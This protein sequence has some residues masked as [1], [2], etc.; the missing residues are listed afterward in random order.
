M[1][2]KNSE[3]YLRRRCHVCG[4]LGDVPK[5]LEDFRRDDVVFWTSS[6]YQQEINDVLW[7]AWWCDRCVAEDADDI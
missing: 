2:R 4:F 5:T 7:S 1:N 6:P 3:H